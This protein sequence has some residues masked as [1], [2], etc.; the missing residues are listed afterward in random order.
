MNK[1][2]AD[3]TFSNGLFQDLILIPIRADGEQALHRIMPIN[4]LLKRSK[5]EKLKNLSM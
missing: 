5:N 3:T 2:D 4:S 1:G